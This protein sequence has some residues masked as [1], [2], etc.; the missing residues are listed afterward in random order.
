MSS[1]FYKAFDMVPH[2]LVTKLGR[3]GF[4]EWTIQWIM[5]CPY[6]ELHSVA[7]CPSRD[8]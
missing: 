3:N 4:D 8:Q 6:P 5:K 7:Q 1:I 2:N